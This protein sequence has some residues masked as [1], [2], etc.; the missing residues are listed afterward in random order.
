MRTKVIVAHG[1]GND[2]EMS[3]RAFLRSENLFIKFLFSV[4]FSFQKSSVMHSTHRW[5]A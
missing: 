3:F 5:N 2:I 1:F 4:V